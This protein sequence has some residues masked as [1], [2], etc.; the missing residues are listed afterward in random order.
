MGR[1]KHLVDSTTGMEGFEAK[2]RISQG[3]GLQYCAPNQI[4]TNRKE[5][6]VVIPVIT[7][8]EGGITLPMG[9]VT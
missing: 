6:E 3:V 7:F 8:I 5:G 1:F 2:Y 4:I 9:K